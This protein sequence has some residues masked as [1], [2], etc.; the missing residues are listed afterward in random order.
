MGNGDELYVHGLARWLV[1]HWGTGTHSH[2]GVFSEMSF[3][4]GGAGVVARGW[5][6]ALPNQS[7][8]RPREERDDSGKGALCKVSCNRLHR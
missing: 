4:L 8:V 6:P 5:T 1:A 2:L 7:S 3:L